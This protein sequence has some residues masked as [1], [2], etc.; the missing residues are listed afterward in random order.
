MKL[1]FIH[2]LLHPPYD[3]GVKNLAFRIY[4]TLNK[5]HKVSLIRDIAGI[6]NILNSLILIPRILLG[7]VLRNPE[8]IIYIPKGALTFSAL[9]KIWIVALFLR[10]KLVIVS[11][12]RKILSSWQ[13]SIIKKLSYTNIYT[14]SSAMSKELSLLDID[15]RVL[16]AGIDQNKFIPDE[17]NEALLRK[18]YSMPVDK[19]IL[20][21]VGHIRKTRNILWLKDVQSSLPDIQVIII[22]STATEQDEDVRIEL[23][24]A[25]V[26]IF[27]QSFSDIQE[28]YQASDVYCFP[29]TV[30]DG[31]ME[32]PLSVLE[33]MA[34]NKPVLTT[35]FGRLPELFGEDNYYRYIDSSSDITSFLKTGFG[36][37]CAN[38]EKVSNYTWEHT[39]ETLLLN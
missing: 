33:A 2:E 36:E 28:I 16:T 38:R 10:N 35:R 25:G 15:A 27:R 4:E 7:V 3:E 19:I 18:K 24:N 17:I 9:I 34:V 1:I 39:A 23:E 26:T 21:H 5:S 8:R 12:Q 20:L 13:Q 37:D 32:I 11:V 30:C 29:V 22:G 6:P 14:L 31:A